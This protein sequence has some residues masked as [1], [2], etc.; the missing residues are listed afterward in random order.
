MISMYIGS[1][2]CTALLAGLK[3]QSH[4]NLL[5][6]FVSGEVPYY[7]ALASPIDAL[8]TGAILEDRF[9]LTLPDD[10]YSQYKVICKEQDVLKSSLDF[11]QLSKGEVV[12]FIELKSVSFLDFMNISDIEYIKGKYKNYYNQV[13]FQLYCTGLE[14]ATL[15]F[16]CVYE[17]DDNINRVRE[18]NTEIDTKRFR[19]ERDEK[20]ITKIRER[21]EIFQN[22]K[23]IYNND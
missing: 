19:I 3:T 22:L 9:L 4:L 23:N 21:A 7:N 12:D 5:R 8:R 13:Q 2:D 1:G 11:A 18:I 17:Y 20:V 16:L 10:Y 14:S 6:R 15:C